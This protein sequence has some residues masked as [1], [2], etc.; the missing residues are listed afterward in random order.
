MPNY[1]YVW[2]FKNYLRD[3]LTRLGVVFWGSMDRKN[4]FNIP[5]EW[6]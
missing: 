2:Q 3:G 6:F 5:A 1:A 4:P